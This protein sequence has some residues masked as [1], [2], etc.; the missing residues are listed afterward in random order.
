MKKAVRK[1]DRLYEGQK[2]EKRQRDN[3][4]GK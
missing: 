4:K 2:G 1:E 3:G